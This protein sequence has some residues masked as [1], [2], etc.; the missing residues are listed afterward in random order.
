MTSWLSMLLLTEGRTDDRILPRLLERSAEEVC[1]RVVEGSVDVGEVV[2]VRPRPGPPNI[3]DIVRQ[4]I[5]N[6]GAFNVL[7]VHRDIGANRARSEREWIQPIRDAWTAA[8]R[9]EELVVAAPVRET[10]AWAL[11]DG[12][13]LRSVFGVNWQDERLKLPASPKLVEEEVDPKRVLEHI[14]DQISRRSTD[15]YARLGD[16]IAL[17]RLR[18]V[19]SFQAWESDLGDALTRTFGGHENS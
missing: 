15:Y 1:A 14:R 17:E 11:A 13:A 6:D 3:D 9:K 4:A 19:P 10:E 7:L 18:L 8:G 5:K 2:V 12:N 16:L